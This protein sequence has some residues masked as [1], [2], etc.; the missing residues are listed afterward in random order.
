MTTEKI[1]SFNLSQTFKHISELFYIYSEQNGFT[2]IPFA[3]AHTLEP[4]IYKVILPGT[5]SNPMINTMWLISQFD[6][7][8]SSLFIF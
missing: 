1:F 2:K 3:P 4:H 5:S 8:G 7:V 6:L